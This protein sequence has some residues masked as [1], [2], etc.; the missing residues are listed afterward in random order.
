MELEHRIDS[1][2]DILEMAKREISTMITEE[3]DLKDSFVLQ[4]YD[5]LKA[6][7]VIQTTLK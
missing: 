5:A 1:I 4:M 6:L 2:N 7:H 3:R